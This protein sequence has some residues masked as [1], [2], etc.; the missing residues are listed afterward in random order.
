MYNFSPL[1][2]RLS[3]IL[4]WLSAE[5]T[6][7]RT[8]RASPAILDSIHA[9][10]YG[11]PMP[12][13]QLG[14]VTI[15][16]ARVLRVT[17]W[18]ATLIKAVEKAITSADLG[19]SVGV[20]EK[21]IRVFFPELTGERRTLLTKIAK[22]KLEAARISVRAERDAVSKDIDAAEDKGGMGEDDVFRLKGDM[23][24][25]IDETNKKLEEVFQR[26]EKEIHN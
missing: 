18:D 6:Q 25:L 16:D 4:D 15:E 26:K 23:Q 5:Y 24:K 9:E 12:L 20:D 22:E 11:S 17:V 8:G 13:S 10:A 2:T 1:K 14:S 7:V 3:E 19:V 21:G